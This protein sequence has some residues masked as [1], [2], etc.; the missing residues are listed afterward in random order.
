MKRL[1]ALAL[2]LA[3]P[4]M[5][6]QISLPSGAR[7][8]PSPAAGTIFYV[9]NGTTGALGALA[10]GS[11][12]TCLK[13]GSG[14]VEWGACGT[15]D[16]TDV[17]ITTT[18]PATGGASCAS[19]TCAFTLGVSI[20]PA[21]PGGAVALQGATPGTV[22]T[23][24]ANLSGTIVAGAFS[25]PLTGNV[26]GNVSGSSGSTTGNAATATALAADPADCS[27]GQYASS[28]NDSGTLGCAQV[29][30]SQVSGTPSLA[31]VAT[32]G[33]AADLGTGTLPDDR[34]SNVVTAGTCGD[35]THSCGLTYDA[36][37]RI[38]AASNNSITGG[39]T[40]TGSGTSGQ[41][42]LWSGTSA[43]TGNAGAV[44]S[45]TGDSFVETV[46]KLVAAASTAPS[47]LSPA[48]LALDAR[49]TLTASGDV[50]TIVSN[51]VLG[52]DNPSADLSALRVDAGSNVMSHFDGRSLN[53]LYVAQSAEDTG[54]WDVIRGIYAGV[55]TSGVENVGA[56][57]QV[58]LDAYAYAYP[59]QPDDL[60]GVRA[61][62]ASGDAPGHG[63]GFQ[64]LTP[65]ITL[66]TVGAGVRIEDQSPLSYQLWS[67]GTKPSLFE[68]TNAATKGVLVKGAAA[69]SANLQEWQ[70]S[71]GAALSA[72]TAAGAFTGNAATA[73]ALASNPSDCSAGQYANAIAASGNLT[74]GAVAYSEV[75]G[76]PSLAAVAT[77]GSASDLGTGTLP[78]A[79]I[80]DGAV[81]LAKLA[82]LAQDQFIGRTTASTG[83]PETAT[84][85]AAART[86]LDDTSVSAMVD[87]LGGA[88][89]SGTGGL[90]RTTDPAL[91]RPAVSGT[92]AAAGALGYDSASGT[93]TQY[94]GL[95]ASVGSF[96]RVLAVGRPG[97]TLTNSTASDQ[98]F[99]SIYTIPANVLVA[100]KVIR[101]TLNFK[102]ATG[103]SSATL[104]SYLKLGTT[105]IAA[106]VA[107]NATD[108]ATRTQ[109]VITTILGTA[110]A[111]ASV[112][113]E[114]VGPGSFFANA[115]VL[116]TI[117]QPV[118]GI[119]TNGTLAIVPGIAWSSTGSTET[120]TLLSYI[121]EEL[122]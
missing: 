9:A 38:T 67:S 29:A 76:T 97:G 69:Q 79:R 24:H 111:G 1:A 34:L 15:G 58:A 81:T 88:A 65:D 19:G 42:T 6:Q 92:P 50:A 26:T 18:A 75:S 17:N 94:S 3:G 49:A 56:Y 106:S 93:T 114:A 83:V 4:A 120:L 40:I 117:G 62:I 70:D 57:D 55:T 89:A 99:S 121:I 87:T 13:A 37:G 48:P 63:Y 113:V 82:N 10:L 47:A 104:T 95:T 53:G 41:M 118:A 80:A 33:S 64:V 96:P 122:N 25:G 30:Y 20:T 101:V 77:S 107:I 84:I 61:Q 98:D 28:I 44:Y 112:A 52:A 85:T 115:G 27:A 116:G 105:K 54:S 36:H 68:V 60:V 66:A 7:H 2:L 31:A 23:G 39:G 90:A 100:N 35:A 14:A 11:L 71:T 8:W 43:I 78:I 119:A 86:V 21:N 46:S 102:L 109:A 91:V 51:A 59:S 5:G 22:Q 32:S 74:C 45:G 73:T 110:A 12:G 103:V 16:V 108:S 72:V